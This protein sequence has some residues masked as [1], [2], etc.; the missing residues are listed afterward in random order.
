[1]SKA[2]DKYNTIRAS[3]TQRTVVPDAIEYNPFRK[4][5]SPY[6]AEEGNPFLKPA[7]KNQAELSEAYEKDPF[8]FIQTLYYRDTKNDVNGYSF[9]GNDGVTVM[10]YANLGTSN[11]YGYNLT[12]KNTISKRIQITYDLD[13]FHTDITAPES[14]NQ[15]QSL[16]YNSFNSDWELDYNYNKQNQITANITYAGKNYTLGLMNPAA[17]TSDLKYTHALDNKLSLTIELVN[18]AVPQT[19]TS[20]FFGPGFSGFQRVYQASQL[21][22]IG[23]AKSF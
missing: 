16:R 20:R 7:S 13:I 15:Y 2:L 9:L 22:R 6:F 11:A 10:S 4:Y 1:L 5:D 12:F 21:I 18:G 19:L 23:L 14:L 3:F 8:S 17:W